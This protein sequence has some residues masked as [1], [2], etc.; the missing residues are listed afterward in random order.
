MVMPRIKLSQSIFFLCFLFP[1]SA[2]ASFIETTIGTAV[3]NDATAAYFNPAAL[4]LLKNTQIIPLGSLARFKTRFSGQTTTVATGFTDFGTSP[5][6]S[7]YESP[8]M[9]FGMPVN[10]KITLGFA[11]VSNFANRNPEENAILRYV[12]SSNTI[13]DYDFVPSIGIQLNKYFSVGAGINFSRTNFN[14]HP[15]I[16][17]PG[18][19]IADSQS[20]NRSSG[21]GIGGNIGFLLHP[22][23]GTLIGFDYRTVTTYR[24]SGTS[25]LD[26]ETQIVSDHYRFELRTPA[27]SI[28]SIS[29]KITRALGF[30]TTIQRIQWNIVRNVNIY[31]IATSAGGVP[32]ITNASVPYYLHNTW[33]LTIG[34]NYQVTPSWIIRIA[35]TYNQSPDSG[36]Y[37]ISTGDS[38]ILGASAGYQMN[39]ILT[40]DGSYA[41]AFIQNKDIN[42]NGNRFIINGSNQASR[43]AV[44]LKLTFNL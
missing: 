24:E 44:S 20:T 40:L 32:I 25:E 17:F 23:Q 41:H 33:L 4:M 13:Q 9:Y 12:Q 27:R 16:G 34:G 15:I 11:A 30:I 14:L 35:G 31:G 29:Q 43:D 26:G 5:S 38:Y 19:N 39:K 3:V 7:Y 22:R 42:I 36:Y 1:W 18:S 8:S 6:T 2:Y 37:Q 28:L 10:D 21:S